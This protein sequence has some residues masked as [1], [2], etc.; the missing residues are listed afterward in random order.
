MNKQPKSFFEHLAE[1][2]KCVLWCV[3]AIVAGIVIA[4]PFQN[5][6]LKLIVYPARDSV[7]KLSY[8]SPTE[9]FFIKLKLTISIGLLI[10]FPIII[11]QLWLFIAPALYKKE[12]FWFA[13]LVGVSVVLF[14]TGVMFAYWIIIPLAMAFFTKFGGEILEA[15]ITISNYTGF[16]SLLLI[17][18][19]TAFQIPIILIF[20]MKSG[21]VK[22]EVFTRNRGTVFVIILI[23]SAFFTPP[24]IITMLIMA[25][26]LYLLFELSIWTVYLIQKN[27]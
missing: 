15:N 12:R 14:W 7:S 21:I 23:L 22:K 17:A 11:R 5:I 26:P 6:W 18:A 4:F 10:A 13:R 24:D 27:N 3:I 2:R 1:L 8:L 25:G 9:P 20:L 19:G 16:A